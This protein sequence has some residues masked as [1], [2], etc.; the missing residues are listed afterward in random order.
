MVIIHV[1]TLNAIRNVLIA[2]NTLGWVRN[3]I[4]S[5][6][7]TSHVISE[8]V[9]QQIIISTILVDWKQIFNSLRLWYG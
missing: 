9:Q 3:A 5:T 2:F 8:F 4:L 7:I 6:S 1:Y